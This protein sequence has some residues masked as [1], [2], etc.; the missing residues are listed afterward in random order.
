MLLHTI[1]N[2]TEK[3]CFEIFRKLEK[4]I[5]TIQIFDVV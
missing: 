1:K 4:L 5:L 2:E 3:V